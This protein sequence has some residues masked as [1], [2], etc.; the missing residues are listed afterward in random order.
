MPPSLNSSITIALAL[1]LG[2]ASPS[3]SPSPSP[4]G[5]SC[6]KDAKAPAVL[7]YISGDSLEL[8]AGCRYALYPGEH[9]R[10]CLRGTWT[11]VAGHSNSYLQYVW[12][13]NN[14]HANV[15]PVKDP[16]LH[17]KKTGKVMII[18]VVIEGG[19]MPHH[20]TLTWD[21]N[22]PGSRS[23]WEKL[24][25]C[26]ASVA[27]YMDAAP[28]YSPQ[29]T[30]ITWIST[31][32]WDQ[33]GPLMDQV[34]DNERW[35]ES[36][37]LFLTQIGVWYA[38]CRKHPKWCERRD[39][40]SPDAMGQQMGPVVEKLDR[41]CGD[42][43][44]RGCLLMTSVLKD[45]KPNDLIRAA[46][47]ASRNLRL[48]DAQTL[49]VKSMPSENIAGHGSPVL[50]M[51]M[52]QITLGSIC[53]FRDAAPEP[54]PTFHGV[55][56]TWDSAHL[57]CPPKGYKRAM[58]VN[59]KGCEFGV[60]W[61]RHEALLTGAGG[62]AQRV[63]GPNPRSS[64]IAEK[65]RPDNEIRLGTP[66]LFCNDIVLV[67][68]P[69]G[70]A[71]GL[72][73]GGLRD[74]D[75][76][77]LVVI[78]A[79]VILLALALTRQKVAPQPQPQPQPQPDAPSAPAP[80][81]PAPTA[82]AA[83]ARGEEE[84]GL[85]EAFAKEPSAA[86]ASAAAAPAAGFST[87]PAGDKFPLGAARAIAS[88]H[89]VLGHLYAKGVAGDV[90]FFGWGF[91]WVPWFFMLSG[92]VNFSAH[93]R[94]PKEESPFDYV[95]RRASTIYPLYVASLFPA[96][97]MA[98][99]G[100][101]GPPV[102]TLVA[103]VFLLQ[104][105]APSIT[106]GALQTQC[107]F[108]SCMAFYWF[109]FMPLARRLGGLA[110][111][112]TLLLTAALMA[113]PWLTVL[114]PELTH[115]SAQWYK[116][117]AWGSSDTWLDL[118]VVAL[119][120]HPL[121]YLHIFVLGMLLANLRALLDAKVQDAPRCGVTCWR[122]GLELVL[123]LG[124]LGLFLV[125]YSPDLCG[126]SLAW[127][128]SWGYKLSAR[129]SV[130]LPLQC[131]VLL[132]LAG[133]PSLPLPLLASAMSRLNFLEDYSFAVYVL[134][135]IFYN[136]WPQTGR[137]S[138]GQFM[139]LLAA[140]AFLVVHL[141]QQPLK[142]WWEAH[143][144]AR[145]AVP[146]VAATLLLALSLFM[147]APPLGPAGRPA[148]RAASR[149]GLP[150]LVR[151]DGRSIDVRLLLQDP[152]GQS[153]AVLMNPALALGGGKVAI[154]VRRHMMEVSRENGVFEGKAATIISA[155]WH[156]DVMLGE[157]PLNSSAWGAWPSTGLPPFSALVRPWSGLRTPGGE[158]WGRRGEHLCVREVWNAA[159]RT[160]TRLVVTG[161]EDAKPIL[162][163]SS[164]ALAFSSLPPVGEHGCA[165]GEEVSRMYLARD[166][167]LGER[168]EAAMEAV[169]GAQLSFSTGVP[170]GAEK[171]WIP[172]VHEG[173]L[174]FVYEPHP[175]TV[176][177]CG[178]AKECELLSLSAEFAP[179]R[180]LTQQGY[181]VRGSGQ[182]V[183]VDDAEAT[184]N[185]PRRHYL[186]L[187]H[188]VLQGRPGE[189]AHYAYRFM[190]EPPFAIIQM[191]KQLPLLRAQA[192]DGRPFAFASGLAL[193]NRTVAV[194]YGAGDRDVRALVLTLGRLDEMFGCANKS[195][196]KRPS[197]WSRRPGPGGFGWR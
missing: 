126:H 161:P 82:P 171:N 67:D 10:K 167:H 87:A 104:A 95:M 19:K 12:M 45:P 26:T 58:C 97:A 55:C 54:Y 80:T 192:D 194:T 193:H 182:A 110:L 14:L 93:L 84:D 121:C 123:P 29:A 145:V 39:L 195:G 144:R 21:E 81:A 125:F 196:P 189:Y 74:D 11:V 112:G 146:A 13:A 185:L 152:D 181:E 119:K 111:R 7:G 158:R 50:Y 99:A 28:A 18:D 15:V 4:S 51:W 73:H 118:A 186:A 169:T 149:R 47:Q 105:W 153:G 25:T 6:P 94:R 91:T 78:G 150:A 172:F 98:K 23:A 139:L 101:G 57:D 122:L 88:L 174:H 8:D 106:E 16:D 30:R 79:A 173:E 42:S 17:G 135:F 5:S 35:A 107:W 184:P 163:G 56:Y 156:S 142:A 117:H 176:V 175:H 60:T 108:L 20:K 59:T 72:E 52:W 188:V 85:L 147:D 37:V 116:A 27:N 132:G 43:R 168:R 83:L 191:S 113:L 100:G 75:L 177:T 136:L 130:L 77:L 41:K 138:L 128:N 115:G 151:L 46:V 62:L 34:W 140:T 197:S 44:A 9:A 38:Y 137:V 71:R 127:V 32:F 179:L 76:R 166:V 31:S 86:S 40:G 160:L 92:F 49:A 109:S 3:P 33:L 69:R 148:L 190:P 65:V 53:D 131:A 64:E 66:L 70:R 141:V 22:C 133:L 48:L 165:K 114:I 103:Q 180:R 162:V 154:A 183:L 89:V 61:G 159:N 24:A 134:Q 2:I 68:L 129:L 90:Y 63:A 164:A 155:V 1:A 36:R 178:R 170:H 102:A 187:I 143:P 120:F 124:Y 157:A 96:L